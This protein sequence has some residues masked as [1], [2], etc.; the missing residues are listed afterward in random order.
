MTD[1]DPAHGQE[2]LDVAQRERVLTYIITTRRVTSGELLKYRNGLFMARAY[3]CQRR[4]K[5]LV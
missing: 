5:R 4:R 2:I 3:H 1:V